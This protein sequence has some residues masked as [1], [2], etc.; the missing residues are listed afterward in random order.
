MKLCRVKGCKAPATRGSWY[1]PD[2][3]PTGGNSTWSSVCSRVVG[4]VPRFCYTLLCA[5]HGKWAVRRG[6]KK[7]SWRPGP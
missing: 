2:A 4:D 5:A 7:L 6:A 3:T 1:I